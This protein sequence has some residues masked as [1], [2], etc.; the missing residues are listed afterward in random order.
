MD[1][2]FKSKKKVKLWLNPYEILSTGPGCGIIEFVHDALSVDYIKR[3]LY[4]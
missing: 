1:Q 3:K 2:I 4:S